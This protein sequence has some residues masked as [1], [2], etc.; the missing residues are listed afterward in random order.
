MNLFD[1]F[2]LKLKRAIISWISPELKDV[3]LYWD[4][5]DFQDRSFAGLIIGV[6]VL[7]IGSLIILVV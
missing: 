6:V 1:W 5:V 3:D 4:V 2:A 7:L